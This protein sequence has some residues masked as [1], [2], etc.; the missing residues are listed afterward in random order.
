MMSDTEFFGRPYFTSD[1]GGTA[2]DVGPPPS[3][4]IDNGGAGFG[5]AGGDIEIS[6]GTGGNGTVGGAAGFV[7]IKGGNAGST[8]NGS[9]GNVFIVPGIKNGTGVDGAIVLGVSPSLT[10]RGNTLIGDYND[11]INFND[12]FDFFIKLNKDSLYSKQT[13]IGNS[14]INGNI[15][16]EFLGEKRGLRFYNDSVSTSPDATMA[17]IDAFSEK[18]ALIIGGASKNLD[19]SEL[20]N[21][22]LSTPTI[23]K[24]VLTGE[25]GSKIKLL[26]NKRGLNN[27]QILECS[28]K[29]TE[30]YNILEKH[31]RDEKVVLFSPGAL[32]FDAYKNYADRGEQFKKY[33]LKF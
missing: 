24:L 13:I 14:N 3:S 29:M 9:G 28:S 26:L 17:A 1:T 4:S 30:I 33:F 12:S 21:K 6:G 18:I 8:G 16:L 23:Q 32:S 25:E 11:I 2:V 20:V 27:I 31:I 10:V 15:V 22:I 7:A 5:G 19:Y